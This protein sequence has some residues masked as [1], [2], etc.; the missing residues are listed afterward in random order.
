MFV[1]LH[2]CMCETLRVCVVCATPS[3]KALSIDSGGAGF[4]AMVAPRHLKHGKTRNRMTFT[5]F[6]FSELIFAE[7]SAMQ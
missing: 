1:C 6:C 4:Q 7:D 2:V 3:G 5:D